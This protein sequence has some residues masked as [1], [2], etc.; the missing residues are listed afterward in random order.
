[1][2]SKLINYFKDKFDIDTYS[3]PTKNLRWEKHNR[4]LH[5]ISPSCVYH[6]YN[7]KTNQLIASIAYSSVHNTY[8]SFDG[9]IFDTLEEAKEHCDKL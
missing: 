6:G 5:P 7:H 1:M 2:F 3:L 8:K 4:H 9:H